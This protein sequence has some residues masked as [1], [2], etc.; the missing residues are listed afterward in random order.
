MI[1]FTRSGGA[2]R[3]GAYAVTVPAVAAGMWVALVLAGTD[4]RL[5]AATPLALAVALCAWHGG[6]GP[7]LV[8][9]AQASIAAEFLLLGPGPLFRALTASQGAGLA[10]FI[11]GWLGFSAL[12]GLGAGRWRRNTERRVAAE[13]A[14]AQAGRLMQL[15]SALAQARTPRAAIEVA[16]HEPL[17]ALQADAGALLLVSRDGARTEVARLVGYAEGRGPSAQELSIKSPIADAV[18]RGQPVIFETRAGRAAD[19]PGTAADW[20]QDPFEASLVVPLLIGIRVVA[21]VQLDFDSPRVLT[22]E[23]RE[24]LA[25]LA[26]S[27]AHAL[28]RSWQLELAER[29]RSAAETLRADA[30]RE[31]AE[32]RSVEHA[33]RS[34]ETRYRALAA[35][36]S[37]LHALSAALSE[38]VTMEAVARAVITHGRVVVGATAGEVLL[39]VDEGAQLETLHA[40]ADGGHDAGAARVPVED[41]LCATAAVKTGLPVFITSLEDWQ[42]RFWRSASVAADGGY[43]SSAT[44]PLLVEGAPAGVL[45]FHFTVPVN[46]DEEYRA[47]LLSVAQHCAQALD[48]ARLY[49]STQRARGDAERANR[50]KDEFVSIVSHELRTPL[51]AILGW[52]DMLQRGILPPEKSA[53]ALQSVHDNASRQARLIEE[54]LDFSRVSSGRTSLQIEPVDVREMIRGVVESMIPTAVARAVDLQ[55]SPVPPVVVRGDVRRL[56]QICFNLIDN[57]LK[58]TPE[59]GRVSIDVRLDRGQVEIA[60]KDTGA[61][62]DPE[63]LPYVF[64]RFRQA[65]STTSRTHGG[66]GLGLSIARQLV[67]A[68]GGTI[69][70]HSEGKGAGSAFTVRLPIA[71]GAPESH[72]EPA[73]DQAAAPGADGA[74]PRLDGLRVLVVDDEAD[75]RDIMAAA[76]EA[77]GASVQVAPGA[78]VAFEIL[79]QAPVDVLLSDIAMPD[80]DGFTLIR[81]I[82]SSVLCDI[83]S[84][85]AAAVTAF[86]SA[87]DRAR[88]LA[89]GFHDMLAKPFEPAQLVRIVDRLAHS[90]AVGRVS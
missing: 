78:R 52:T 40:E 44:M 26:H 22:A 32:R 34:S 75:A 30:D 66:L 76:L 86:T 35:R 12:A 88:A 36:T 8:A 10:I 7:G 55:L 84:I 6:L 5:L 42:Q 13:A 65:D 72:E 81:K 25:A 58:F 38:A 69:A 19:Y 16:V 68:H 46:F 21:V 51:N 29:G 63:F 73:P 20:S 41:G 60:V 9:L 83:A 82:R 43:Q 23:D 80:V 33:L 54:L 1:F 37:R 2:A 71:A 4:A 50:I 56:E 62:M 79:E 57:A 45:T 17:H 61:G 15:T 47:L 77:S 24:Y 14:A 28:D 53:R 48:R 11:G 89:A 59:G 27:G 18:D 74:G 31:L 49:E 85:P 90:T 67:E 3:F 39:L 70:A 64:D 87:E